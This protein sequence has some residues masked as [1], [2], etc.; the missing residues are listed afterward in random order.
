LHGGLL[1]TAMMCYLAPTLVQLE[2]YQ[3]APPAAPL[4]DALVSA[5]GAAAYSWLAEDLSAQGVAGD[6]S[7]ASA[8]LGE[9]LVRHYARQLAI[10][11]TEAAQLPPLTN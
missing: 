4:G 9:R 3:A 2:E 6:A 8:A 5:E 11:V 7:H 10:V 1:E